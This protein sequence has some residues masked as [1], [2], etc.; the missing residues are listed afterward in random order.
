MICEPLELEYAAAYLEQ[1][2]HEVT[3]LDMILER[4]PLARA[5]AGP[6]ARLVGLTGYIT[7][8]DVIREY[9]R[10]VKQFNDRCWVVVGGVHAEVEPEAFED[11]HIDFVLHVDALESMRALLEKLALGRDQVRH[12][13]PGVW[14][15]PAKAYVIDPR[16]FD[17]PFPD[18]SKTLRYRHATTTSSTRGAPR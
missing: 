6:C 5:A 2:G 11:E 12:A 15:G 18:R 13:V 7:H 8:V 16:P 14:D 4:G 3:I 1:H 9:A 10:T 17:F